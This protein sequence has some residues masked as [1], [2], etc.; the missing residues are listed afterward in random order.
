MRN[1]FRLAIFLAVVALASCSTQVPPGDFNVTV[2]TKSPGEIY[3]GQGVTICYVVNGVQGA[4]LTLN[5][6]QTYTFSINTAG[7]P[8]YISTDPVGGAGST[9][10]WTVGVMGNGTDVGQLTFTPDASAPAT[11]YYVCGVHQYMGGTINIR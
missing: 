3:Y 7:H 6:G 4:T 8:F 5:K 2:A 11:L 9:G 10:E 1:A